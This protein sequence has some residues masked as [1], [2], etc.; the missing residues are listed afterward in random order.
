MIV[1]LVAVLFVAPYWRSHVKPAPCLIYRPK[2]ST[3]YK[4]RHTY[5]K[6]NGNGNIQMG[7]PVDP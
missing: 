4:V 3:S 7:W 2:Q 1:R 6:P 5:E